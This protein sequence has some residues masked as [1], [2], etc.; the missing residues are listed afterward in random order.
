MWLMVMFD[1]PTERKEDRREYALFRKSLLESGFHMVQFSV[2]SRHAASKEHAEVLTSRI[3]SFLPPD[4][5]VRI[6]TFTD[7]QY[8]RMHVFFGKA[9]SRPEKA[10]KQLLLF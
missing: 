4:G 1:L 6:L 10:P 2:Y 8:E 9:R 5:Q 7:K 3:R